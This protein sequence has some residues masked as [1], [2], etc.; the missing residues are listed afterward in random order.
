MQ[1]NHCLNLYLE[2]YKN[3]LKK[4]EFSD[5]FSKKNKCLRV[6]I[7][8]GIMVVGPVGLASDTAIRGI[9]ERLNNTGKYNV[10]G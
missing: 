6:V 7:E 10:T 4:I 3:K 2:Y 5:L 8:H 1:E 9:Y